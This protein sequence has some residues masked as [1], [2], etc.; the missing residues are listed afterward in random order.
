MFSNVVTRYGNGINNETDQGIFSDLPVLNFSKVHYYCDDFDYYNGPV[1]ATTTN[2]YTLSG[3]GG[4]AAI[5]A[6][7]GGGFNLIGATTGFIA[8]WQRSQGNFQ[9]AAGF[10]TW[11]R[12]S[13]QMDALTNSEQMIAGLAVVGATPFTS[14]SDGIWFST[15]TGTGEIS[16]NIAQNGTVTTVDTGVAIV[17]ATPLTLSWYYTAGVYPQ[18]PQSPS[19]GKIVWEATGGVTGGK[20]RGSVAAPANFPKAATLIT[21]TLGIKATAG[22]PT[23]TTNLLMAVKMTTNPNATPLF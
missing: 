4:T 17:A 22:T 15:A 14:I 9:L 12:W 11:F 3:T 13:G 1:T 20:A 5:A 18:D 7:D 10:P 2:G 19:P 6:L 23:L 21:P 16:L 8:T